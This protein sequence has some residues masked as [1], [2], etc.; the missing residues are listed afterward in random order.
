MCGDAA[1]RDR[2]IVAAMGAEG[3]GRHVGLYL[4]ASDVAAVRI[5]PAVTILTRADPQLPDGYRFAVVVEPKGR[6]APLA[7]SGPWPV[8]ALS[9]SGHVIPARFVRDEVETAVPWQRR[10]GRSTLGQRTP[11]STPPP[12]ACEIDPLGLSH[13]TLY[14]GSVVVHVH[15]SAQLEGDPYLSCAYMQLYYRGFTVQA[16]VLLDA[17]SP[18][19]P[20]ALLPDSVALRSHPGTVNEPSRSGQQPITARRIGTA[21]GCRRH[22]RQHRLQLARRAARRSGQAQRVR[23][24]ARDVLPVSVRRDA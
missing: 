17:R 20:P 2:P 7:G 10:H 22:R 3:S 1:M 11:R 14:F 6:S 23:A 15:P 16:V 18:G 4:T 8:A 13:A 5:S 21:A 24:A 9:A 12:A 19:R